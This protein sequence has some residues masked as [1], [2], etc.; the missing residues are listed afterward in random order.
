MRKNTKEML[1]RVMLLLSLLAKQ[2]QNVLNVEQ[3]HDEYCISDKSRDTAGFL[4]R[5]VPT[6]TN[7][8]V[9]V[10]VDLSQLNDCEEERCAHIAVH[11]EKKCT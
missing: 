3:E 7:R 11:C 10:L 6:P 5:V 2:G 1:Q 9:V 8:K 4:A